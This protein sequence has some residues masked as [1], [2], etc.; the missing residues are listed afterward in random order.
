M[1]SRRAPLA[2]IIR[3][4]EAQAGCPKFR[5]GAK[6]RVTVVTM[7]HSSRE[8]VD[9]D[10]RVRPVADGPDGGKGSRAAEDT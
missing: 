2:E 7:V 3:E 10:E 9:R 1:N 5:R 8:V 4:T 6:A